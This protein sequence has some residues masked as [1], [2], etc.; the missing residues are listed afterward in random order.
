MLEGHTYTHSAENAY[1]YHSDL[2]TNKNLLRDMVVWYYSEI[3]GCQPQFST[4]MFPDGSMFKYS[5][6]KC[7]W[8][9]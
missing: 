1:V 5:Q 2:G 9:V 7:F 6:C 4:G 8:K 3:T